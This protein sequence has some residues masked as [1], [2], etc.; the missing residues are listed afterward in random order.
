MAIGPRFVNQTNEAPRTLSAAPSTSLSLFDFRYTM[1]QRQSSQPAVDAS[2][3]NQ[4][5]RTQMSEPN[6]V[7]TIER[8][9]NPS[10]DDAR[11]HNYGQ[12]KVPD[13]T[14]KLVTDC[15]VQ[16]RA[17]LQCI[18]ENYENKDVACAKYFEDYKRCRREEHER[19]MEVNKKNS[20]W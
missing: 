15:R 18:E 19:K 4:N 10:P 5:D 17:S 3:T 2:I 8:Q 6:I 12:P 20:G 13:G 16:Q 14:S 11:N 9:S 1:G 7:T